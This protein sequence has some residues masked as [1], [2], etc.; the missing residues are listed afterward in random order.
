MR[1]FKREM[2]YLAISNKKQKFQRYLGTQMEKRISLFGQ[3]NECSKK[4]KC[5]CDD[6]LTMP[7]KSEPCKN[8]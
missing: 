1:N 6:L 5:E 8:D 4:L 7:E 2:V 3:K